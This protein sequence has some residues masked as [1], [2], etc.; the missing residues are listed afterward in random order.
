[1]F[2]PNGIL[3]LLILAAAPSAPTDE[4]KQLPSTDGRPAASS[5]AIPAQDIRRPYRPASRLGTA[6]AG[7]SDFSVGLASLQ[8]DSPF[9]EEPMPM[10]PGGPP[11]EPIGP[12][13]FDLQELPPPGE[14][15]PDQDQVPYV[16]TPL[17]EPQWEDQPEEYPLDGCDCAECATSGGECRRCRGQF[18][19]LSLDGWISQ[20]VTINTDSPPS[21]SN[22]PVTFNDRSNDYQMNQFYLVLSR[23]V[24]EAEYHWDVGGRVDLL[25]G[26]DQIFTTA[27][28]LEVKGDLS[29]KWNSNRYGLAMPQAYME[30]YAPWGNGLTMKLGHFYTILGYETVPAVENFFYSKSLAKQYGEPFTHTGFLGST[31]LGIL[32]FQAGMTRGWDNWEDNNNDLG[33]LG[34]I[35]WT[36]CDQC[37]SI[38][39]AIHIGRE[40]DEP[41]LNVNLRTIYSLVAQ[42]WLAE[43]LL[44]VAQYDHGFEES[45]AAYGRDADWFG[46]NQY[47][48]YTINACWRAGLRGEWFRDEDAVRINTTTGADYYELSLGLNWMP[49]DWINVRPELRWDWADPLGG[50][51]LPPG[52]RDDQILLACDV[53]ARF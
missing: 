34:G 53:V 26:T 21:G 23:A 29:P 50:G 43:R 30:V 51:A 5:E 37:T 6:V 28:G 33:F 27:R 42:H 36:S 38:A 15:P 18:W 8:A 35:D 13:P 32:N 39:F 40:Q 3:T 24:D 41:P 25:Y 7:D 52:L 45:G 10:P 47:L 22:F 14:P 44:Y 16:E 49:N 46:V 19:G 12:I 17:D 2:P 9:R 20:G 31:R 48:Y 4:A 1:M 11:E